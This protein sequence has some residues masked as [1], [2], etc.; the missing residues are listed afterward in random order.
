MVSRQSTAALLLLLERKTRFSLITKL[1]QKTAAENAQR[2]SARLQGLPHPLRQTI[3][4]D[5]GSE[6]TEHETV[7]RD[8]L[9]RSYFCAP[10]H[11]REKGSIENAAGLVR[12]FFP[13]K[14][15]F[16]TVTASEIAAVEILLNNRPQKCLNY[17]RPLEAFSN[18][19]VVLNF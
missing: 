18:E 5:N 13:K 12:R 9:T 1:H 15:D 11:S 14:T 10:Y 8:L 2:I 16:A 19:C 3:T 7:N 17:L 4:Y 6:N